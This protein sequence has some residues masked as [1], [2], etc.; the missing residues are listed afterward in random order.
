MAEHSCDDLQLVGM[1]GHDHAGTTT[2]GT[3]LGFREPDVPMLG[4]APEGG[5][6]P[7]AIEPPQPTFHVAHREGR[8]LD[9]SGA[10]PATD[11]EGI[12]PDHVE[13]LDAERREGMHGG[14]FPDVY[15]GSDR[16][17]LDG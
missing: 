11:A 5:M 3:D 17:G 13:P 15:R 16:V 12:E 14:P 7:G 10:I 9:R 8:G 2:R 1:D 4:K 6:D